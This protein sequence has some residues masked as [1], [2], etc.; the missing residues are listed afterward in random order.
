M[1]KE[2]HP[3]EGGLNTSGVAKYSDFGPTEG[4][5]SETVCAR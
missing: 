4:H 1:T 2:T 3:S 5:T